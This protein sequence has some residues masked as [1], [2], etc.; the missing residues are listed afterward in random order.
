MKKYTNKE[1]VKDEI[2]KTYTKFIAE[3][4][5]ISEDMKVSSGSRMKEMV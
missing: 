3:F 5:N 4:D 1:E 2:Q